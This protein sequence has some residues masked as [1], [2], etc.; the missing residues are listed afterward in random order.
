MPA[1]AAAMSERRSEP[2]STTGM[3]ATKMNGRS[4]EMI[5]FTA[6]IA[7]I[8]AYLLFEPQ[9]PMNSPTISI[10]EIARKKRMPMLRSATPSPGAKGSVA[11]ISMQGTRNTIGARL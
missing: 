9:P 7:E 3:R 8:S 4:Y 10:A 1:C 6:R 5:W 2:A 11:K